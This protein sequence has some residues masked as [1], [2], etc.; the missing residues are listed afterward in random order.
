MKQ[1]FIL[2]GLTG[3][4]MEIF[5]TGMN[6]LLHQDYS[7]TGHS[8][9]LMFPIYGAAVIFGPLSRRLQGKSFLL[10]GCIY[11]ICIFL[12]EFLSG[13]LLQLLQI[14]PWDYSG[15]PTNI[16]GLIRLDYAPF[17][18]AAS[19]ILERV[20]CLPQIRKKQS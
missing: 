2:C 4:F 9:V 16:A 12:M 14:C 13:A 6:S 8:S 7:L 20:A 17:W 1:N 11:T 3:L 18:F 5:F 10:R 19:L 15:D